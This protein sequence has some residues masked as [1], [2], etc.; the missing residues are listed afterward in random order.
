MPRNDIKIVI[1]LFFIHLL[2]GIV[3]CEKLIIRDKKFFVLQN[4]KNI[5]TKRSKARAT[6][7]SI[8][9]VHVEKN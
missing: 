1:I 9:D 8:L 7:E 3:C 4:H 2:Q 5:K 6:Y